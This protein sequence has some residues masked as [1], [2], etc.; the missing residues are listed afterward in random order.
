MLNANRGRLRAGQPGVVGG[1]FHR[2]PLS[3][4]EF[5]PL[6]L[7]GMLFAALALILVQSLPALHSGMKRAIE[8]SASENTAAGK[9]LAASSRSIA[10][11]ISLP[12]LSAFAPEVQRWSD[13]IEGWAEQ[14]E[15]PPLLI[16]IVM[17]IESC[18]DPTAI[19]P[20]GAQGLFQ[21]MPFHFGEGED[22]LQPETNAA[23]GL[24]Y[25]KHAYQLSGARIDLTLAGYNGGLSQMD[26]APETWPEETRRYVNWGTGIWNDLQAGNN[27]SRTLSDWLAAGGTRLCQN[28]HQAQTSEK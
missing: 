23:R 14:Y 16:A 1:E 5:S 6:L 19:S 28:A 20:S 26:A 12:A 27:T 3:P 9:S 4:S 24:E 8:E 17:Q 21:V 7:P 11:P 13:S 25:L 10:L 22:M 18:G 15:L 2:R